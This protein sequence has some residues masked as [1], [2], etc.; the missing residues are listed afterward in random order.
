M[1]K[2]WADMQKVY[3]L[4]LVF[5]PLAAV[6]QEA[7]VQEVMALRKNGAEFKSVDLLQRQSEDVARYPQLAGLSQGLVLIPDP[8]KLDA[9]RMVMHP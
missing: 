7:V 1:F 9:L 8:K 4:F 3:A 5:C 2:V 6:C